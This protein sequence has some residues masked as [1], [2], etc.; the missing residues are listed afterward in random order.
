MPVVSFVPI[1]GFF[2]TPP[3][4]TTLYKLEVIRA[5]GTIDNITDLVHACEIEDGVTDTI[6][7]FEFEIWDPNETYVTAWTGNEV[8]KY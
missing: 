4:Y 1:Q 5:D 8:F 3:I 2:W 6:G 7:R